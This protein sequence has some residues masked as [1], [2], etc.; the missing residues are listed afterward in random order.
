[1]T[2][3]PPQAGSKTGLRAFLVLTYAISWLAWWTMVVFRIPGGS[4]NPGQPTPTPGGLLL[5]ALGGFAPSIVGVLMTSHAGGRA[6]L[7]DLWKRC[8]RF[9]LGSRPYFVILLAPA[10]IAGVRVAV[11]LLRGG[12]VWLPA[13]LVQPMLLAGFAVQIFLFGPV[14]EELGWRGFALDRLLARWGNLRSSLIL[15]AIHALWHLPLFFVPGTI[16]QLWGDPVLNFGM[17]ALGTLGGAVVFTWLHLATRGSVWAAIMYHL[18]SNCSISL[19]W[20]SFSGGKV[21]LLVTALASVAVAAGLM[22][23]DPGKWRRGSA[24]RF[25][26]ASGTAP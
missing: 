17:F 20:M 15:G 5:L 19:V 8:I 25:T 2:S 7:R 24:A 21:D 14:S 12:H 6:G 16:Q 3:S 13:P 10:L 4:V 1:M 9:N 23:A 11:Q 22:L 26:A 18:T